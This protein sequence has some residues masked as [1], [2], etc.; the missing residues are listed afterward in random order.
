MSLEAEPNTELTSASIDVAARL[1]VH[2]S[3]ALRDDCIFGISEDMSSDRTKLK[4]LSSLMSN[5]SWTP[6]RH[7]DMQSLQSP[8]SLVSLDVKDARAAKADQEPSALTSPEQLV[9]I[10]PL[11]EATLRLQNI[12]QQ[13]T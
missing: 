9:A 5:P 7:R 2:K 10:P 6:A 1:S 13:M 4:R 11:Q 8:P 3:P 12:S